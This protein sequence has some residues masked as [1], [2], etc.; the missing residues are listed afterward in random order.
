MFRWDQIFFDIYHVFGC[1]E[2]Y[3]LWEDFGTRKESETMRNHVP[4]LKTTCPFEW[5]SFLRFMVDHFCCLRFLVDHL[6]LFLLSCCHILCFYFF[7]PS[8]H[9]QWL[10]LTWLFLIGRLAVNLCDRSGLARFIETWL[11]HLS[12]SRRCSFGTA[13][14]CLFIASSALRLFHH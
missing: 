8:L 2:I 11:V 12:R 3:F 5:F 1:R 14:C 10:V 7:P 9:V 13:H 4:F 6:P